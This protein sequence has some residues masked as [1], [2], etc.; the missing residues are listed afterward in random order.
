MKEASSQESGFKSIMQR[1][2]V[3][4]IR[5]LFPPG[6]G[7]GINFGS[8]SGLFMKNALEVTLFVLKTQRIST[9]I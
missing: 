3:L 6:S 8:G 5:P 1:C 9:K 2:A 4:W 7:F